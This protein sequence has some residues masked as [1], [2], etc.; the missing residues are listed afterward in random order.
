MHNAISWLLPIQIQQQFSD[1]N[2]KLLFLRSLQ[3]SLWFCKRC[4]SSLCLQI[5]G[6][7]EI[8]ISLTLSATGVRFWEVESADL[9]T[10]L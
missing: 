4:I 2:F 10:I 8:Q 9:V 5:L 3:S 6:E 7:A 1:I